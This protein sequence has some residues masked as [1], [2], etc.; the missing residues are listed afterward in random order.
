MTAVRVPDA[1]PIV[2]DGRLDE[3]IWARAVPATDFLQFDP[4]T[5]EPATERTEVR[6][7]YTRST[8]YLLALQAASGV[9]MWWKR[10]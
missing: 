3:A 10:R 4:L 8:L 9:V 6:I 7:V 1:E 2:V 5:G